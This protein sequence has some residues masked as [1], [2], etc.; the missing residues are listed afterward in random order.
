MS[1]I[2]E[3]R[4][5]VERSALLD[6]EFKHSTNSINQQEA[7]TSKKR[8]PINTTL[9][10]DNIL[11]LDIMKFK[12]Y[13]NSN[14]RHVFSYDDTITHAEDESDQN[15]LIINPHEYSHVKNLVENNSTAQKNIFIGKYDNM[16]NREVEFFGIDYL[17]RMLDYSNNKILDIDVPI[18]LVGGFGC[19]SNKFSILLHLVKTFRERDYNVCAITHNPLGVAF[20]FA[21]FQ[22]P[23]VA[24]F[25]EIVYSINQTLYNVICKQDTE[26]MVIDCPGA[27]V[28]TAVNNSNLANSDFGQIPLAY[29]HALQVDTFVLSV[30]IGVSMDEIHAAVSKIKSRKIP[31]IVISVAPIQLL[32]SNTPS[33]FT[34]AIYADIKKQNYYCTAIRKEFPMYTCLVEADFDKDFFDAVTANM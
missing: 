22:Y 19:N 3:S 31:N 26:V 14:I 34:D 6:A 29:M 20:D 8:I 7:F 33:D 30:P 18:V 23:E 10:P 28:N 21:T 5:L 15:M 13:L 11:G 4:P 27:I 2:I 9:Y 32:P 12:K 17:D 16:I 25:P 24:S 1:L